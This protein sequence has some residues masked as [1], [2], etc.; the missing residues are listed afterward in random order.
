[1]KI[2]LAAG[3]TLVLPPSQWPLDKNKEEMDA[4]ITVLK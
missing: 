2:C 4:C 1:M 3:D